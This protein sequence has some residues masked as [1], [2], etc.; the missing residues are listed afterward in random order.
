MTGFQ[1]ARERKAAQRKEELIRA[2]LTVISEKGYTGSTVKDVV[3]E[4]GVIDGLIY[5]YFSSKEELLW[6][7]LENYNFSGDV[8]EILT[9]ID[10]VLFQLGEGLLELDKEGFLVMFLI[11]NLLLTAI[12]RLSC[13]E[14]AFLYASRTLFI[15]C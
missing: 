7:I 2:A 14:S 10:E 4:A 8:K 12:S 1:T 6:A 15:K 3:A 11:D 13:C 5:H 9:P